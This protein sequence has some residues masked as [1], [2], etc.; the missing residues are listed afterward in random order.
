MAPRKSQSEKLIE[1]L[2]LLKEGR[3]APAVHIIE[4]LAKK[5]SDKESGKKVHREPNEYNKFVQR[6]F[7]RVKA[8]NPSKDNREIMSLLG[9]EWKASSKSVKSAKAPLKDKKVV[10][11]TVKKSAS[12]SPKPKPT[13]KAKAAKKASPKPKAAKKSTKSK[14]GGDPG[15]EIVE[16][17]SESGD[18]HE[19]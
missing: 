9:A 17:G 15:D 1:V 8:D 12:A 16:S 5:A 4:A 11:K 13:P 2:S 10:K 14:K 6:N 19:M 7:A 3:V 18:E